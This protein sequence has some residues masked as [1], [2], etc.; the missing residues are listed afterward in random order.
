MGIYSYSE[1]NKIQRPIEIYR[2][3]QKDLND[4]NLVYVT[5]YLSK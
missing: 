2:G 1:F 4:L 5:Y 3:I